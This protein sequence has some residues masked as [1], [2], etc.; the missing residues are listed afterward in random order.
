MVRSE[1]EEQKVT[2]ICTVRVFFL[3][4]AVLYWTSDRMR[5][6]GQDV[7]GIVVP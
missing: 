7:A 1:K 4:S 6:S 3:Y 2:D 5:D